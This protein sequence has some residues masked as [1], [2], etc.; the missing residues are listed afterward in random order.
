MPT[1]MFKIWRGDA[2]GG[3]FRDYTTEVSEAQRK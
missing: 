1:A 2:E 3:A